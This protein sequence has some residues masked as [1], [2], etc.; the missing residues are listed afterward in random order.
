MAWTRQPA[1]KM[2]QVL[3]IADQRLVK[4][5]DIVMI[6]LSNNG[7]W[8]VDPD[9]FN[10]ALRTG[11]IKSG[12]ITI[13]TLHGTLDETAVLKQLASAK[14]SQG[15][16]L[17][18]YL[19]FDIVSENS[20]TIKV[21]AALRGDAPQFSGSDTFHITETDNEGDLGSAN[22]KLTMVGTRPQGNSVQTTITIEK[23]TTINNWPLAANSFDS[24]S[25]IT[26]YKLCANSQNSGSCSDHL[27][28]LSISADGKI[29]SQGPV[30]NSISKTYWLIA[31]NMFGYD[32]PSA[33]GP[34]LVITAGGAPQGHNVNTP[35]YRNPNQN[36]PS[37]PLAAG[38]FTIGNTAAEKAVTYKLCPNQ[39]DLKSCKETLNGITISADQEGQAHISGTAPADTATDWVVAQNEFGSSSLKDSP[40]LTVSVGTPPQGDNVAESTSTIANGNV[41]VSF[42]TIPFTP[43][44]G[45]SDYQIC[46]TQ[47]KQCGHTIEGLTIEL[48]GGKLTVHGN[49]PDLSGTH[50]TTYEI[51]ATNVYGASTPSASGPRVLVNTGPPPQCG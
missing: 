28:N 14:D 40:S 4:V 21:S 27:D 32:S 48:N 17:G 15:A 37:Q 13:D 9:V 38:S 25:S 47:T 2:A 10:K 31:A 11:P 20:H 22:L 49:A 8:V 16:Q 3:A 41:N 5:R 18:D 44:T 43:A 36:I 50:T 24:N 45:I 7:V 33:D 12:A 23:G 6:A 35:L 42:D 39:T 26:G 51:I 46:S 1:V 30:D 29:N 34:K 19:N